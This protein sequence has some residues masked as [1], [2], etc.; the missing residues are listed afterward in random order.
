MTGF[1]QLRVYLIQV[2]IIFIIILTSQV[3]GQKEALPGSEIISRAQCIPDRYSV[4]PAYL[5]FPENNRPTIAEFM[6]EFRNAYPFPT[7]N[8]LR[9]QQKNGDQLGEQH[10]RFDQYYKG[11]KV[12]G[13]QYIVHEKAGRV[14]MANG[15]L[16]QGL[17]ID[18]NPVITEAD[19]FRAALKAVGAKRYMWE[20]PENERFLQWEQS[21]A[22]ASFFPEAELCIT[23]GAEKLVAGNCR[24]VYR[25]DIYAEYPLGRYWVDIDAHTGQTV[26]QVARLYHADVAGSGTSE[27][28]G[29]VSITVD[30]ST[31]TSFRLQGNTTRNAAIRTYTLNNSTSYTNTNITASS[32]NG[33]WDGVGV[34]AHWGAEKT[35]DYYF[36]VHGRDSYNG[37]G[38]TLLSYV[39]YSNNY[40]NAYWDGSRMTYGDG[41]S[42]FYPLVSLDVAAHEMTHGVTE[43]SAGLIY[44][45]EPGAMNEAF[46]DIFGAAVEFYAEG[47]AGDWLI[48]ED[49]YIAGGSLR[50]MENPNV[51]GD[52]DTYFGSNWWP[53]SN[54]P[55]SGNDYGGVHTNSSVIN[56]WFYLLS[57]GGSGTN[58]NNDAFAVT[59]IGIADAAAVA[60]RIL[61]V[62]L[63]STSEFLDARYASVTAATDLF[64]AGSQQVQSVNDAWDAVGVYAPVPASGIL[65]YEGSLGGTDYSGN[66]INT[67]LTNAGLETHYTSVFPASLIGYDAV[68]LSFGNYGNGSSN[69]VFSASMAAAVTSYLQAGGK[70]YLEGGDALG[71]DQRTN[72]A[73]LDLFGIASAA[74]GSSNTINGLQGQT[75]TLASGMNFTGSSQSNSTYIDQYT[76]SD[77]NV[78]FIESG[79]GNVGVQNAGV[80]GQKT[81]CFSYALAG[82]ND[83]ASPSTKEELMY[84]ITNYFSLANDVSLPVELSGFTATV[85]GQTV[86]L[87][88]QTESEQQNLGFILQRKQVSGPAEFETIASY[89]S[90]SELAGAGNSSSLNEYHFTDP[91]L[92]PGRSYIYRLYDAGYDG[93]KN[94][95]AERAVSVPAVN[96]FQ[97]AGNYPNPFNPVT[98]IVFNLPVAAKVQLAVYDLLGARIRVLTDQLLAAGEHRVSWDGRD[99]SGQSAASGIYIYRLETAGYRASQRMLLMK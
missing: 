63:T 57:D 48:G 93:S 36:N 78:L 25:F 73:L 42:T 20:N 35:Y 82:V 45:N 9:L 3:F 32:A 37:S 2:C 17:E 7:E 27:Y 18:I 99:Q 12:I 5:D 74:D 46:S 33:P 90:H 56:Y 54:S 14:R 70:V 86:K 95:L 92:Q 39:H 68:F 80:H 91:Q 41:A 98:T 72:T 16:V 96:G 55:N 21:D 84:T 49:I 58:D 94:I 66:Y 67:Y 24:L 88:W 53:L 22:S 89:S 79:Y 60:Y 40:E 61:T 19:A 51:K 52:P 47:V 38:G 65:V 23:S 34:S 87:H 71:W 77:G 26:N 6:A 62:Y 44:Q 69:T 4:L 81:V 28:N 76:V 29:V 64:G 43:F 31:P 85:S 97:L 10:S 75:G 30:Q 11:M 8:E 83:G 13:A 50:S 1:H 15:R 59:G